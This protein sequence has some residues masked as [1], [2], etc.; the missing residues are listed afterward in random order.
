MTSKLNLYRAQ[1]NTCYDVEELQDF[2]DQVTHIRHGV[3]GQEELSIRTHALAIKILKEAAVRK[4][5]LET[6]SAL[7]GRVLLPQT[8]R[9]FSSLMKE[10]SDIYPALSEGCAHFEFILSSVL[11]V[12]QKN[13]LKK[14]DIEK[15]N[16]FLESVKKQLGD[17]CDLYQSVN[18]LYE[19]LTGAIQRKRHLLNA[20][21][22]SCDLS[23]PF[24][25]WNVDKQIKLLVQTEQILR[26]PF[27]PQFQLSDLLSL[28]DDDSGFHQLI[29]KLDGNKTITK[30]KQDFWDNFSELE[31]KANKLAA[32]TQGGFDLLRASKMEGVKAIM[33]ATNDSSEETHLIVGAGPSGL[34]HAVSLALQKKKF[35][36]IE[37]RPNTKEPRK[38]TVTFG[39]WDPRELQILMFLGTLAHLQS[40]I[41]FGHNR[42]YYTETAL[43]D[44][45]WA[46]SETLKPLCE[47]QTI[48]IQYNT[49]IKSINK[50]KLILT[51]TKGN[52]S[53]EL[54]PDFVF[55][56]DGVGGTTRSLLGISKINL[57]QSTKLA[58]SIYKDNDDPSLG[59]LD[60]LR[61]RIFN[62]VRGIFFS[63]RIFFYALITWQTLEQAASQ[64][65]D[66]GPSGL[67][68]IPNHDYLLRIFRKEEQE[69]VENYENRIAILQEQI[70]T[71]STSCDKKEQLISQQDAFKQALQNRLET[72]SKNLHGILDFAH[73]CFNRRGHSMKALPMRHLKTYLVDV[74]VGKAEQSMVQLGKITFFLRGDAS[75][76]TDPYSGTGAKTAIEETVADHYFLSQN[77]AYRKSELEHSILEWG[78]TAYQD[79]MLGQ[80]FQ[81]RLDYYLGTEL[82][83]W[84]ADR[85]LHKGLISPQERDR[86]IQLSALSKTNDSFSRQERKEGAKLK[87]K[88]ITALHKLP[89]NRELPISSREKTLLNSAKAS[90]LSG[91]PVS[92]KAVS[93]LLAKLTCAECD[94][95]WLLQMISHLQKFLGTVK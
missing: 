28:I 24:D 73:S 58:F 75:H 76:T 14:E 80:A 48:P 40:R 60:K 66:D 54:Q 64:Y 32:S 63:L 95:G 10:I 12:Q 31:R 84:F 50:D 52:Y 44:L 81:E 35:E 22:G 88:L 79:R 1:I 57:S 4:E 62:V 74:M 2:V 19:K 11:K 45:E 78:F 91:T 56:T 8:P 23:K 72:K 33:D 47:N 6:R 38:N 42:P 20:L 61:Y 68:R 39:K 17:Q 67:S 46:L 70:N 65:M 69:I 21:A 3:K 36:I 25:N 9:P 51:N 41:S 37:K 43:G 55:A 87:K 34:I 29:L 77:Q 93:T 7:Y 15:L 71:S 90:I 92:N 5:L 49:Q 27:E 53:F 86:Y 82:P 85:A 30:K 59:R 13:L 16:R 83:D 18:T 89:E 26:N 94:E